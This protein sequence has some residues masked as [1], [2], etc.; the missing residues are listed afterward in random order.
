MNHNLNWLNEVNE[1]QKNIKINEPKKEWTTLSLH[2]ISE[3][4][5]PL[6]PSISYP[7]KIAPKISD[8]KEK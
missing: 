7:L 2:T 6:F 5:T 4:K 1:T 8:P 3:K